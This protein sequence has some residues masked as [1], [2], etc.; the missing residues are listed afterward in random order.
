MPYTI[1]LDFY[2]C[3]LQEIIDEVAA[4]AGVVEAYTSHGPGGGNPNA[5]ISFTSHDDLK[6]FIYDYCSGDEI[7]AEYLLS[8]AETV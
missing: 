7:E 8:L 6:S 1:N 5:T 4:Y 3:Y 2:D